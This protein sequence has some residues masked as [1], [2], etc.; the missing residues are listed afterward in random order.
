MTN[1]DLIGIF[2]TRQGK[3]ICANEGGSIAVT[4]TCDQ[5][6]GLASHMAA[7]ADGLE[8]VPGDSNL[9]IDLRDTLPMG[10]A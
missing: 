2:L 7:V 1:Q 3:I 9:P 5:L 10:A 8:S 4:L 6:R